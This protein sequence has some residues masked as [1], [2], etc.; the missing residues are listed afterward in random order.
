MASV[1]VPSPGTMPWAARV[2]HCTHDCD[3]IYSSSRSHYLVYVSR[4]PPYACTQAG[5]EFEISESVRELF[6][7]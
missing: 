1:P 2:D 3:H 7:A 4:C 6:A 5:V